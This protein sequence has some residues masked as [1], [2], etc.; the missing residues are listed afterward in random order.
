MNSHTRIRMADH[1][2]KENG[3]LGKYLICTEQKS[4]ILMDITTTLITFLFTQ[5][6]QL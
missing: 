6:I 3:T 4:I 2:S 5:A 1:D